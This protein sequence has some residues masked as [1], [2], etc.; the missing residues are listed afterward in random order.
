[1]ISFQWIERY[2][3]KGL[4]C[5]WLHGKAPYQKN[6]SILPVATYPELKKSYRLGDNLG[7]RVGKWSVLE[8]ECGLV[9]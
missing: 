4:A 8:P 7:V 3:E 1:M 5:H 9:V 2:V 6:W